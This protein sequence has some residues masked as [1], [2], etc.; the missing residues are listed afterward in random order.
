MQGWPKVQKLDDG[1]H[2]SV[3]VGALQALP[4]GFADGLWIRDRG[5]V[6]YLIHTCPESVPFEGKSA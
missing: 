1:S 4:L 6:S 2:P 5:R 3:T